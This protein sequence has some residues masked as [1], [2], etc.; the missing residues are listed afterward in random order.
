MRILIVSKFKS[1][2]HN[3]NVI[4]GGFLLGFVILYANKTTT[5]DAG[6]AKKVNDEVTASPKRGSNSN[7]GSSSS[8]PPAEESIELPSPPQ[9]L[10]VLQRRPSS[11]EVLAES[12]PAR[13]TPKRTSSQALN[14]FKLEESL[15][16]NGK[17][18]T[19]M[20]NTQILYQVV[21]SWD[22]LAL[23][24]AT[25][26]TWGMALVFVAHLGTMADAAELKNASK[27]RAMYY[28]TGTLG[29]IVIGPLTD[30]TKNFVTLETY[31]YLSY[32]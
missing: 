9:N 3:K 5:N 27:I 25:L 18:V 2:R 28:T 13:S 16:K 4:T 19:M 7:S 17:D 24:S 8:K 11:S 26:V 10:S 20:T 23:F 14:D 30:V 12:N 32:C 29:R 6:V 15:K 22:F 21:L 31:S 1:K